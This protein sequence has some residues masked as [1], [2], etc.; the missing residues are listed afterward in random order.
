MLH[1]EYIEEAQIIRFAISYNSAAGR[2][3]SLPMAENEKL[4]RNLESS[5]V[6]ISS[7]KTINRTNGCSRSDS[8]SL[9]HVVEVNYFSSVLIEKALN[10]FTRDESSKNEPH[11]YMLKITY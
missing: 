8:T 4:L 1:I 5:H 9:S 3:A 6:S 7:Q 2:T 11:S 10:G